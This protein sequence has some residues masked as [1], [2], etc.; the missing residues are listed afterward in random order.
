M[1]SVKVVVE[2]VV[3]GDEAEISGEVFVAE[4][5]KLRE[6]ELLLLE[7]AEL[8]PLLEPLGVDNGS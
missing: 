2:I 1:G 7:L 6:E 5:R 4:M 3:V 8:E